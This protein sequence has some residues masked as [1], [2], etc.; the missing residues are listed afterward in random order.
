MEQRPTIVPRANPVGDASGRKTWAEPSVW[1]ERML[2]ALDQG[3]KGFFA[4]Q[5]LCSL[6]EALARCVN[7]L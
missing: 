2:T 7:P 5:G 4:A 6:K 3:V 1:T